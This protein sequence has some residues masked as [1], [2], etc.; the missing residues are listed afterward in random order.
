MNVICSL[1]VKFHVAHLYEV[2]NNYKKAKEGYEQ[3]LG[4]KQLTQQL[5]AD[6]C[7]QLGKNL[8]QLLN[9]ELN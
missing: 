7:R 1:L 8:I 4:D 6:V 3:L 5:K 9:F 2:Q